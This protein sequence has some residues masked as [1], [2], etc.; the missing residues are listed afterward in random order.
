MEIRGHHEPMV[1]AR[2]I[3]KHACCKEDYVAC[4]FDVALGWHFHKKNVSKNMHTP[5]KDCID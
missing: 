5:K 3:N 2:L 4:C 1:C